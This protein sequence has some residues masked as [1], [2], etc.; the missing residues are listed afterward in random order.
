MVFR[1]LRRKAIA[2][3]DRMA[4]KH[5]GYTPYYYKGAEPCSDEPEIYNRDGER[6]KV[7]FLADRE[8][9]HRPYYRK[10]IRHLLWDRY[11]FGL[12]T[13]F[14]SHY[15]AFRTV[16]HPN[17]RFAMLLESKAIQPHSYKSYLDNKSYFE[18]EFDTVFTYDYEILNELANAKFAP[19]CSE[20]W[21]GTTDENIKATPD[22][23]KNK[24][25]NISIVSSNKNFCELHRVRS[26][27][28]R[29]CKTL[30]IADTFGTFDGGDFVAIE[31]TLHH[32]RYS[33]AIEND[34]SP[35]FFTEKI[36]H[37]FIAQTI[38]IY[39]GATKINDFFNPD[40]IIAISLQD[41]DNIEEILKQCTSQE[42][43]RK[44]PAILDNYE[45]AKEF[46]DVIEYMYQH[47]LKSML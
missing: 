16:G 24:D 1:S 19:M 46:E 23:Y 9:A 32:Y 47:Y 2:L 40:G 31:K 36:I 38:P 11:N 17:R 21:Y 33:I 45:R 28:A 7:A 20:G 42:Y 30:G 25:K 35:Y 26:E 22:N 3:F 43:E 18:N 14:Y 37:C 13:H 6:I 39:L 29:K 44:L 12:K 34:I 4:D 8:F 10:Q 15:E 41:I 5:Y 27:L